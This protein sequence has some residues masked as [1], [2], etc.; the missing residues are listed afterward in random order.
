MS[1]QITHIRKPNPQ[2]PHEAIS[3]YGSP[4]KDGTLGIYEREFLIKW[5]ED[6][7][8]NAYV[9]DG[10]DKV[11]CQIRDNGRIKYLQ[12]VADKTWT[13]NLLALPQC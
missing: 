3:H 5:L 1:L 6:N 2:S 7:K 9:A 8:V 11:Q 13:D 4:K 12:T 10:A